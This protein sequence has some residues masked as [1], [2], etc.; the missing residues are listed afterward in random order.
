MKYETFRNRLT[1]RFAL[2]RTLQLAFFQL[3]RRLGLAKTLNLVTGV[4]RL[5]ELRRGTDGGAVEVSAQ[6][7]RVSGKEAG[8]EDGVASP[9]GSRRLYRLDGGF[10]L[11]TPGYFERVILDRRRRLVAELSPDTYAPADHRA[12]R[13]LPRRVDTGHQVLY[14]LVTPGA[15]DNYYHWMIDLMPKCCIVQRLRETYGY[16]HG[17]VSVLVNSRDHA[18]QVESLKAAGFELVVINARTS[19]LY[20]AKELLVPLESDFGPEDAEYLRR[21]F[22]AG[23]PREP[24]TSSSLMYLTRGKTG[25]RKVR[26]ES[27]VIARIRSLGATVFD[28]SQHSVHEQAERFAGARTVIGFHGAGLANIVFCRKGTRIVEVCDPLYAPVYYET[29]ARRLRLDYVRIVNRMRFC[30]VGGIAED[31]AVDVD[32]LMNQI[33]RAAS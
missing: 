2:V 16:G 13:Q 9:S 25:R 6:P 21:L 3:L 22:L 10:C 19:T 32:D 4:C 8:S 14:S 27:E 29:L 5:D 18:Y 26:N 30:S 31:I 1:G 17:E 33:L 12:L 23:I 11:I 7:E 28:A 20:S 15:R 24:S